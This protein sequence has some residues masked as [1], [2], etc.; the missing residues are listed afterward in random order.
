MQSLDISIPLRCDWKVNLILHKNILINYF[1]SSKVRLE[2]L[3]LPV[4]IFEMYNFNSSKV[5]LEGAL[6]Y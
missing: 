2:E 6:E 3:Y 5:R 4:T 1:N